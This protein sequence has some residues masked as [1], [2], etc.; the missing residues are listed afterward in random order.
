MRANGKCE[1]V[2]LLYIV[3][4]I[5]RYFYTLNVVFYDTMNVD[6]RCVVSEECKRVRWHILRVWNIFD[7]EVVG[8]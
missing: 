5:Y 6:L 1:S 7:S 4:G 2:L 8:L 3:D